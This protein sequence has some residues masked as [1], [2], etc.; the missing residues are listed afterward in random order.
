MGESEKGEAS[1]EAD[2]EEKGR[3]GREADALRAD[4]GSS[5]S[6]LQG[7]RTFGAFGAQVPVR[8]AAALGLFVAAFVVVY[9]L[10]WAILGGLGLLVGL[11]LGVLAGIAAM[12]LYADRFPAS[13]GDA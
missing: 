7:G 3:M 6:R 10:C 11:I 5:A 9:L 12:K 4:A 8:S 13:E 2:E 1:A